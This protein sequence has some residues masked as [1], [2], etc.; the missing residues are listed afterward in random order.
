VRLFI[1]ICHGYDDRSVPV[2]GAKDIEKIFLEMKKDN[3]KVFLFEHHDHDLN[4]LLYPFHG[5]VSDG[6]E[7]LFDQ[8]AVLASPIS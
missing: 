8:A 6:L 3:L 5:V 2:E 7:T 4:Y 1:R